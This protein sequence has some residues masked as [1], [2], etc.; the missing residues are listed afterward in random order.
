MTTETASTA[1]RAPRDPYVL[2]PAAIEEPPVGF[3]STLTRI[4]PGMVLAAAIVGSGEL[5]ATT[6]LGA[7]AGYSALWV[8]LLS[9]LTKPLIQEELGRYT[10]ATGMTG[11]AA[12]NQLP[13]PRLWKVNW[14]VWAWAL[15]VSATLLQ[16]GGMYGGVSQVMHAVVPAVPVRV[17]M[18]GLLAITLVLLLGGGYT[19]I[20]RIAMIKVALF[21]AL[22]VLA[23]IIL[24]QTPRFFSWSAAAEGLRFQLPP[25]GLGMAVAVFGIT[26][27]GATELFMYPYW[28]LEKGYAQ[29]T[30]RR[31]IHA[32]WNRRARG[33][34][35]VMHADIAVS[36]IIY[37]AATV[38]F[39]LLGAGVLHGMAI[40]PAAADMI[41]VLSNL[42]T[43]TL[44]GWTIGLFYV[45]A[46]ATLYGTIFASTAAHSRMFADMCR[47][48]GLFDANDRARRLRFRDG[49][50]IVLA[51]I[52][53]MLFWMVESPVTMVML[54]GIAQS[55]ML[56]VVGLGAL[57][58]RHR[59]LPSE[60]RPARA[61]TAALWLT[62]ALIV[63]VMIFYA[64]MTLS[65]RA[66]LLSPAR[67]PHRLAL[68]AGAPHPPVTREVEADGA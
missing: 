3:A 38:A 40:V 4:G 31:E 36:M 1:P 68:E 24:V 37:T 2:D 49:F 11:L 20:E 5:I 42:Y 12:M 30:G 61:T 22:T 17:W 55:T 19:R 14:I 18:I 54:G 39:Y 16:V 10:I 13:G 63:V 58:L 35:R 65:A 62:T 41:P 9:C 66:A 59:R 8:V 46:I 67:D 47:L 45:G 57:Y 7:Q 15:M 52:P 6:T 26:G 25:A 56:P 21:T 27:V 29:F 33:W 53:V 51:V 50:V 60:L 34:I 32:D 64:V 23:A 43:Q 44:G 28:C 48:M